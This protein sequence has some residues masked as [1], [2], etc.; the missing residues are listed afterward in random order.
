MRCCSAPRRGR[1]AAAWAISPPSCAAR[2]SRAITRA[3]G[4]CTSRW[5]TPKRPQPFMPDATAIVCRRSATP[6]SAACCEHAGACDRVRDADGQRLPALPAELARARPRRPGATTTAAPWSACSA[7]PDDPATRLEN[8]VGEP[9]ANPYLYIA[10]ADRRRPRRH[11][12]QAEPGP[13]DDEP[14]CRR[15][16]DAA[17]EPAARRSTRSSRSRCFARKLGE[18]F[19]DYFLKLKRNE[20]GRFAQW[21][22]RSRRAA[23]ATSRRDGSR[24]S[25]SIFSSEASARAYRAMLQ[26]SQLREHQGLT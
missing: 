7:A 4:I 12:A 17:D 24:T 1:S 20:P 6:I 18:V 15:P 25:I 2:R 8:R 26:R 16:A 23:K 21:L 11:R 22:E 5:S 19:I 3:A 9:A 10:V 13:R 14:Y